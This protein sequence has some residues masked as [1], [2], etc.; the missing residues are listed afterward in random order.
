MSNAVSGVITTGFVCTALPISL[1]F[2]TTAS[3]DSVSVGSVSAIKMGP[4]F[5]SCPKIFPGF[6]GSSKPISTR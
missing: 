1:P 5:I 6:S 4:W 2:I 3:P